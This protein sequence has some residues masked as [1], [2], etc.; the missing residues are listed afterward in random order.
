MEPTIDMD[1]AEGVVPPADDD[2]AAAPPA[3][4]GEEPAGR[5]TRE[6]VDPRKLAQKLSKK[7]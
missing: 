2:F 1:D 3:A 5:E 6:S 7:K 4:G